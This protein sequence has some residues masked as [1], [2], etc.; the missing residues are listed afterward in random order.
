[1]LDTNTVSFALRG[2][3]AV[4]R[5]IAGHSPRE[6]C[7]SALTVAELRYGAERRKSRRLHRLIDTILTAVA[8]ASFD[9]TAAESYGRVASQLADAGSPIGVMDTQLAAHAMSLGL[10]IVSNNT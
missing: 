3:Q 6:L 8:V 4:V 2:H 5:A 1:M 7:V 10:V 9:E